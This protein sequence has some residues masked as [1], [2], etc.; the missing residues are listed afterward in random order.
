[1]TPDASTSQVQ[2]RVNDK[3]LN[4]RALEQ[5]Y[6][7]QLEQERQARIYAEQ[8]AQDMQARMS[9]PQ[10][11]DDD[12]ESD[13]YVNKKKLKKE[14][15]RFGQ[16][17][18][19][20]TQNE[21]QKA[22]HTAIQKERTDNWLKNNSDFEEVMQ[23]AEKFYQFDPEL[24]EDILKMP[25]SFERQKIVYKNIK[26][27]GLHKEK[28]KEPS[29]QEKIDANRRGPFYQPSS[30]GTSPYS[31]QADYSKAGQK[32]AYEKMQ[33]MKQRLRLG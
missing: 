18:K 7:R 11:D 14:Q 13:P 19:Q 12:D 20:E 4:F 28:V 6:Q 32:E 10:D 23:H 3:E 27:L 1:M 2:D 9:A 16:K 21:I 24:A 26:N 8:Q 5:K 33:Q 31:P 15:D 25:P 30:V 29:V 22:V 17:I